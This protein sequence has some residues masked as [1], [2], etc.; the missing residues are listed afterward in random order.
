MHIKYIPTLLSNKWITP[1]TQG[2]GNQGI[3]NQEQFKSGTEMLEYAIAN[4]INP[5]LMHLVLTNS[6]NDLYRS[7]ITRLKRNLD[8]PY[9]YK[10]CTEIDQRKG[11]HIH[12]MII[13][14]TT[15]WH[16]L[17]GQDKPSSPLARALASM[18]G[19]G[20]AVELC[21]PKKHPKGPYI[22]LSAATL[23]DAA[24]WLSYIFKRRSKPIGHSYMSSRRP[25]RRARKLCGQHRDLVTG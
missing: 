2:N 5:K 8:I 17:L 25:A 7:F 16:S 11:Q 14:D 21:Q 23:Q 22:P 20:I 3:D 1:I 24:D 6:T 4:Y 12:I 13:V 19:S 18:P 10:A 15:D 9:K